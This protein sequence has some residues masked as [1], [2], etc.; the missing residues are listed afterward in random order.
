MQQPGPEAGQRAPGVPGVA[1]VLPSPEDGVHRRPTGPEGARKLGEGALGAGCLRRLLAGF[2]GAFRKAPAAPEGI[3]QEPCPPRVRPGPSNDGGPSSLLQRPRSGSPGVPQHRRALLDHLLISGWCLA[4]NARDAQHLIQE[5][6][7]GKGDGPQ[8]QVHA[9]VQLLALGQ[10]SERAD[11]DAAAV[12][13]GPEHRHLQQARLRA[14]RQAQPRLWEA[15]APVDD[16]LGEDRGLGQLPQAADHA[17]PLRDCLKVAAEGLRILHEGEVRPGGEGILAR[18]RNHL[19]RLHAHHHDGHQH[20]VAGLAD[21]GL[22]HH[23]AEAP[24]P[25]RR[26]PLALPGL[27]ATPHARHRLLQLAQSQLLEVVVGLE[28]HLAR[29]RARQPQGLEQLPQH[30]MGL[31]AISILQ[32]EAGLCA[33]MVQPH[34]ERQDEV[35]QADRRRRLGG[36][37]HAHRPAVAAVTASSFG[38]QAIEPLRAGL[39]AE[40]LREQRVS[41]GPLLPPADAVLFAAL[42]PPLP[43]LFQQPA[44]LGRGRLLL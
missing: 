9:P 31:R 23:E 44:L 11:A 18:A 13:L 34:A 43:G 32:R 5:L 33:S 2:Q 6:W 10:G 16:E 8:G 3:H 1:H 28:E 41:R 19:R 35:L 40:L 42:S 36:R 29:A 7:R 22:P 12:G 17:L 37:G 4:C 25:L 14:A 38:N 39:A 27:Q 24:L 30:R 15:K 26:A 21:L 20:V